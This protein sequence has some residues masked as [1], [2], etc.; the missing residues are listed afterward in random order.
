MSHKFKSI[1]GIVMIL[2]S[3]VVAFA[4][5]TSNS[6][7]SPGQGAIVIRQDFSSWGFLVDDEM[8]YMMVNGFDPRVE[9]MNPIFTNLGHLQWIIAPQPGDIQRWIPSYK[10][11][12]DHVLLYDATGWNP[13]GDLW[14]YFCGFVTSRDPLYSGVMQST[15]HDNDF[16]LAGNNN[17]NTYGGIL[18]GEVVSLSNG[19]TLHLTINFRGVW[20]PS[21]GRSMHQSVKIKLN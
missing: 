16:F 11:D 17:A 10:A 6:L 12:N 14:T 2:A 8:R 4:R 1:V 18:N 3:L 9:C 20:D 15:Y 7:A 13:T 21:T 5:P 19:E